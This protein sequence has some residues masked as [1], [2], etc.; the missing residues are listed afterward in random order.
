MKIRRIASWFLAL[1]LVPVG[2][3]VTAAVAFLAAPSLDRVAA[4]L[5]LAAGTAAV[6][7]ALA[8]A[9]LGRGLGL[10]RRVAA[11]LLAAVAAIPAPVLLT[12][13]AAN[14]R[15][16]PPARDAA[17]DPRGPHEVMELSTGSRVAVWRRPADV[18]KH[19]T[20]V[21]FLH[22]GPGMYTQASKIAEG[23][24][25]RAAGFDTVYFDQAGGG[26][27]PSL[28]VREYTFERAIADVEALRT[29]LGAD[30]L[31]LW[32]NSYGAS[33]AAAY[34][35]AHPERVAG[36]LL[37]SPGTFPGTPAVRDYTPT[38]FRGDSGASG[39]L[40]LTGLLLSRNP[41]LAENL[42]NQ[43]EAGAMVDQTTGDAVSGFVC[44][45]ADDR[46]VQAEAAAGHGG[47]LFA[48]QLITP[49]VTAFRMP[50]PTVGVPTLVVH[51]ACDFIPRANAERYLGFAQPSRL[52]E[53][54]GDGHSLHLNRNV[55]DAAVR[56]FA[57]GDLARVR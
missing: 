56:T 45:G 41:E 7:G 11:A 54:P 28:P 5:A 17:A 2:I 19:R 27:S 43:A 13:V 18:R 12:V 20:P 29:R 31:V 30:R 46:K 23:A 34:T 36:L 25:L 57:A 47:N 10:R 21:V 37:T 1:L 14:G 26:A 50:K 16:E 32:G 6:T 8:G 38:N 49:G 53:V 4:L 40:L 48:N 42:S 22:G 24:T 3:V 52:V 15:T 9:A 33:L 35:A 55:V 44:R 51:G 39:R